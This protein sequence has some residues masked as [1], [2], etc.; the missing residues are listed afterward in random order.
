MFANTVD[1]QNADFDGDGRTDISV[2]R[3]SNGTW[4]ILQSSSGNFTAQSFG[5]GSDNLAPA[6]YDGDGRTDIA[7]WRSGVWYWLNSS[8]NSFSA[9]QF[10]LADDL[11][12]PKYDA[13]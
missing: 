13:P 2:F 8:N 10:G 7:V 5:L 9:V 11:P 6:D 12:V 1:K 3:P 4:Y